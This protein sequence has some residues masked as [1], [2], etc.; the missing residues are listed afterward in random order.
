[1][2]ISFLLRGSLVGVIALVPSLWLLFPVVYLW[3]FF[4]GLSMTLG[5]TILHNQI[6]HAMRSRAASVYQLCL[7]AGAP[8]GA[9][10]CGLTIEAIG[11]SSAFILIA[12]ATL[13]VSILTAA[14]SPLWHL[15]AAKSA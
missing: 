9:W 13:L 4:S 7:L 1:M 6:S 8:L 12:A 10:V 11:L 14:F 5:R 15:K 2:V 3:G